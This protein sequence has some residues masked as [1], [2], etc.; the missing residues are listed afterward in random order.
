[1]TTHQA[2]AGDAVNHRAARN[3]LRRVPI[4]DSFPVNGRRRL[5]APHHR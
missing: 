3:L 4:I 2:A 1:M 5:V